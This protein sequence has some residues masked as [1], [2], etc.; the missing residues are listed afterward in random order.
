M[1]PTLM[2][3]TERAGTPPHAGQWGVAESFAHCQQIA[4]QHYENFPVASVLIPKA[5]RP[6]IC[7]IYAFSRAADDLADEGDFPVEERLRR[8]DEWEQRLDDAC[9]ENPNGP[10][11]T[12]LAATIAQHNIPVQLLHDLLTAFRMDARNDGYA[13]MD[14]L[15]F[16]CRHSANPIGRLVLH[17]F[18][19]ATPERV[20]SSDMICTGLQLVNFWQDLSVDIPRG[21]VNVPQ[22]IMEFFGCRL[23]QLRSGEFTPNCQR[24]MQHLTERAEEFLKEGSNLLPMIPHRRLRWELTLTVRGG[25]AIAQK[26]REAGYNTL[27]ARPRLGM[28]DTLR[29]VIG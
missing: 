24:M 16:Y 18:G 21:R 27:A 12:A 9:S 17:L 13:T 8:L 26:I 6:H 28:M 1:E 3:S 4:R 7:A 22:E 10:I 15:L 23:V 11:F 29:L 20:R 19:L 5:V 25:L 2:E 14:H